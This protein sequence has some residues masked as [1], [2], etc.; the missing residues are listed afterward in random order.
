MAGNELSNFAQMQADAAL[1][2][3]EELMKTLTIL[4]LAASLTVPMLAQPTITDDRGPS[5]RITVDR[6]EFSGV[7]A[8]HLS[9]KLYT[10][11]ST[12]RN[13]R[14]KRVRFFGMRL[15]EIPF[16]IEPMEERIQLK[17]GQDTA[18]SPI[19]VTVY[20]R[21][22]DSLQT[23][24]DA[25]KAG[26]IRVSG[27]ARAELDLGLVER[28]A[29][30]QLNGLADISLTGKF[31]V[32]VPGGEIGKTAAIVAIRGAQKALPAASAALN[33]LGGSSS[34]RAR[35]VSDLYKPWLVMVDSR[36]SLL[37]DSGKK[38]DVNETWLGVRVS[39][40]LV[41]LPDEAVQPWRYDPDVVLALESNTAQLVSDARELSIHFDG[42][43]GDAPSLANGGLRIERSSRVEKESLLVQDDEK[44]VRV[45]VAKRASNSNYDILRIVQTDNTASAQRPPF[46]SQPAPQ[47][48]DRVGVFHL[49]PAGKLEVVLMAAHVRDGRIVLDSPVDDSAFGSIVVGPDGIIGMVQDER[50]G[51]FLKM[52]QLQSS[53]P[54]GAVKHARR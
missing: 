2:E 43:R 38:I 20:F 1:L 52:D 6:L 16:F 44:R 22:L 30:G 50:S 33:Q 29:V 10:H 39:D 21:D 26:E 19:P 13:A 18:A 14:V 24:E 51:M 46:S 8:D 9:F 49:T 4:T 42:M 35:E 5:V 45:E 53:L 40:D 48:F 23:L 31:P 7:S 11:V 15:G 41:V 27:R 12:V 17:A 32:V 54:A 36:Y 3:M 47:S 37:L 28:L 34:L 25:V